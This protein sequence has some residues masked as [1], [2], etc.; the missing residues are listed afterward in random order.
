MYSNYT[1]TKIPA[2]ATSKVWTNISIG[3]CQE[4]CGSFCVGFTY[5]HTVQN[6]TIIKVQKGQGYAYLE[7]NIEPGN[8]VVTH[9]VRNGS[10][11]KYVNLFDV[12]FTTLQ[13]V[14]VSY[15][16]RRASSRT[17]H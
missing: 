9:G 11:G 2:P 16:G 3:E 12:W 13:L 10:H 15:G 4:A 1:F 17:S 7:Y 5:S 6:C 14:L 8:D